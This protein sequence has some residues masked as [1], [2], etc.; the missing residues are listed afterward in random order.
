MLGVVGGII[1]LVSIF[2]PWIVTSGQVLGVT[3]YR[4]E[5]T[6]WNVIDASRAMGGN[7]WGMIIVL[8]FVGL[9]GLIALARPGG[10]IF[11]VIGWLLF[12]FAFSGY[13]ISQELLIL[14]ASVEFGIGFWTCVGGSV[15]A[16]IGTAFGRV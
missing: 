2:L 11:A 9:G 14:G 10:G 16:L 7:P 15:L 8:I 3:Y 6:L 12:A 4:G 5:W 13:I 1:I